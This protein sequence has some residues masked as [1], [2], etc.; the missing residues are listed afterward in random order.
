MASITI[1]AAVQGRKER[2]EDCMVHVLSIYRGP[3]I[4]SASLY[5]DFLLIQNIYKCML[6]EVQL[7]MGCMQGG[8]P[9]PPQGN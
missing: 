9:P 2:E 4:S 5:W 7:A 6:Y 8:R 1:T 3:G